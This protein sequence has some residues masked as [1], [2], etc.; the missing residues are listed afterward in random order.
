MSWKERWAA[1][2]TRGAIATILSLLYVLVLFVAMLFIKP[3]DFNEAAA[4]TAG[5]FLAGWLGIALGGMATKRLTD[6]KYASIKAG[7]SVPL[8]T[9]PEPV[10]PTVETHP[11]ERRKPYPLSPEEK[12]QIE[13]VPFNPNE[14]SIPLE[15]DD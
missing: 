15:L 11:V 12:S 13:E 2:D 8:G 9:E 3:A 6:Y 1:T 7:T 5:F 14:R 10:E 4:N